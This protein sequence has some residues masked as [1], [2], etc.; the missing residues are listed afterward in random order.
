MAFD[1]FTRAAAV[2]LLTMGA[3]WLSGSVPAAA[4]PSA[5]S[6]D[7]ISERGA[8][9][10]VNVTYRCT[11]AGF[12]ISVGIDDPRTSQSAQGATAGS[13]AVGSSSSGS[14]L[15]GDGQPHSM[16]VEAPASQPFGGPTWIFQRG[17]LVRV[18]ADLEGPSEATNTRM[19]QM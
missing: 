2:T 14:Q 13:K 9:I 12:W 17:E 3:V 10:Y 15:M 16:S 5:I 19:F 11:G 1:A 8:F 18:R 7:G 4:Q 6:I